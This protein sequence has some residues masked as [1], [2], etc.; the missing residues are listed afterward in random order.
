MLY[1][2]HQPGGKGHFVAL[3]RAPAAL[4]T[5]TKRKETNLNNC[6]IREN[7]PKIFEPL[8]LVGPFGSRNAVKAQAAFLQPTEQ[9]WKTQ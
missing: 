2:G 8:G 1:P 5:D 4:T 6:D 7:S 9:L 3:L